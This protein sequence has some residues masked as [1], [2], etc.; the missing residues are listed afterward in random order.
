MAIQNA[1][2]FGMTAEVGDFEATE[3][4][5]ITNRADKM[6]QVGSDGNIFSVCYY[7]FHGDFT[8]TGFK[9]SAPSAP[10]GQALGDTGADATSNMKPGLVGANGGGAGGG[11]GEGASIFIS[12]IQVEESAEEFQKFTLKGQWW[13]GY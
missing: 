2:P 4:V 12:E 7:N 9:G 3:S 5:S 10:L 8:A 1:I 13:T 11:V 6:E